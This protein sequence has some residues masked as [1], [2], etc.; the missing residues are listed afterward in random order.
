MIGPYLG[1]PRSGWFAL[2]CIS[3][4]LVLLKY[5]IGWTRTWWPRAGR[6]Q[7]WTSHGQLRPFDR[8]GR[9]EW[10]CTL[11]FWARGRAGIPVHTR[12]ILSPFRTTHKLKVCLSVGIGRKLVHPLGCCCVFCLCVFLSVLIFRMITQKVVN[13]FSWSFFGGVECVTSNR[14]LNFGDDPDHDADPGILTELLRL[15]DATAKNLRP[16]P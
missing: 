14:W 16:T 7:W 2:R 15:R 8:S 13:E 6:R 10:R 1:P 4:P 9:P 5:R 3:I 11:A 12:E